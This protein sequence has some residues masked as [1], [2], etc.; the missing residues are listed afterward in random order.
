MEN[1]NLLFEIQ[2]TKAKLYSLVQTIL[3]DP[4]THIRNIQQ[5]KQIKNL[6]RQLNEPSLNRKWKEINE[7]YKFYGYLYDKHYDRKKG[8]VNG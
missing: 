5:Y 8:K 7:G 3:G 1:S 6:V 4:K 2:K